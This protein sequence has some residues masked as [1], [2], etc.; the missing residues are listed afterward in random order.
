[1]LKMIV[2]VYMLQE[3]DI[4]K[5]EIQIIQKKI[6]IIN[7]PHAGDTFYE[8]SLDDFLNRLYFLRKLGFNIPEFVF[9][10]VKYEIALE[11]SEED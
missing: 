7:I 10:E 9:N 6:K 5:P 1:M 2:I 11:E 4:V 3:V 8:N